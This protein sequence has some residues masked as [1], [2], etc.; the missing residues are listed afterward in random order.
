MNKF[1]F[2]HTFLE[3]EKLNTPQKERFFKLVSKE[4]AKTSDVD[5]Q[6]LEDIELIKTRLGIDKE[7]KE[8][9]KADL[10]ISD[11]SLGFVEVN[12]SLKY[13]GGFSKVNDS[14][15]HTGGF[16]KV[17][18]S[19]KYKSNFSKSFQQVEDENKETRN[20]TNRNLNEYINPKHLQDFLLEYNQNPILKYTCHTIDDD[21][22]LSKIID[23]CKTQ[24][25]DYT[26]HIKIIHK[27]YNKLSYKYKDKILKNIT[28]L[29][30]RYLGTY[31]AD[32][33][34]SENIKMKWVSEE[35]KTWCKS[36]SGKVPNPGEG[37]DQNESFGFQT[38]ELKNGSSI[39]NFSDLVIYFKH[40][41]HI[42]SDNKLKDIIDS[43]IFLKF[44]NEEDYSI[45]FDDG[46]SDTVDLFTYVEALSQA[47]SK[48][49]LMSKNHHKGQQLRVKLYFG[50]DKN[51]LKE[52]KIVIL[53]SK[54]YGKD[55]V[56]FRHGDDFPELINRQINGLCDLY[57]K[58][59]F[60]DKKSFGLVNFWNGK[61][62]EFIESKDEIEGVEFILKMY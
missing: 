21:E 30:S 7:S 18:D 12:D 37:L 6:V 20:S 46:F 58:A 47:F 11:F 54:I 42:K 35:L 53:N 45:E 29:I 9:L 17:N 1:K 40:L 52:F 22:R 3:N 34:W 26:E 57:I 5:A 8:K 2:I 48:I 25:Y 61:Q 14:L 32:K 13:T 15:K 19:L 49:I 33:G 38:I 55:F 62:M 44:S 39:S 28:G 24:K 43:V 16:S 36:N 60:N 56:D 27:N 41:F 4:L 31:N 50:Y 51:N 10:S 23:E 59:F